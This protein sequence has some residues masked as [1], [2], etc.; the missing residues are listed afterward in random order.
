[1]NNTSLVYS[2]DPKPPM[3]CKWMLM[4]HGTLPDLIRDYP[5]I[6]A[7]QE[8]MKEVWGVRCS[9]GWKWRMEWKRVTGEGDEWKHMSEKS[10]M[11][12]SHGTA[13]VSNVNMCLRNEEMKTSGSCGRVCVCCS[14]FNICQG[15]TLWI[16]KRETNTLHIKFKGT[17]RT[18]GRHALNISAEHTPHA[19]KQ[20]Q[21]LL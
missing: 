14:L 6:S 8:G 7:E 20:T 12:R 19:N 5:S 18:V 2:E 9:S 15:H 21:T 16:L 1:M 10:R 13:D 11:K 4:D 3:V 17:T